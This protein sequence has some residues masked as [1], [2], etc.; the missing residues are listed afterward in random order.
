[1]RVPVF[2][3]DA[4]QIDATQPAS[5]TRL[6]GGGAPTMASPVTAPL[7]ADPT[8]ASVD[9]YY[10]LPAT[11]VTLRPGERVMAELP[12]KRAEQGLV[13]PDGLGAVRHSRRRVGV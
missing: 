2:A 7:R 3:G 4:D 6:G 11:G 8:A 10:E 13:V 12:L 5:V 1:M 9:L